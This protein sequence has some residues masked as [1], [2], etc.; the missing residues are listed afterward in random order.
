MQYSPK[1]LFAVWFLSRWEGGLANH[2]NDRGGKTRFGISSVHNPDVDLDALTLEGAV[3]LYHERYYTPTRCE[4]LPL[5]FV[6]AVLGAAAHHGPHR[7]AVLLQQAVKVKADGDIGSI[8][9]EAARRV[10]PLKTLD[11]LLARRLQFMHDIVVADSTQAGHLRGWF[12]RV[13]AL[14]RFCLSAHN[15]T[16][17]EP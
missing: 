5:V 13:V 11:D 6:P 16:G 14:H 8:T 4:E 9:L 15:L 17:V 10:D 2:V 1:F 7:S 3:A 12:R